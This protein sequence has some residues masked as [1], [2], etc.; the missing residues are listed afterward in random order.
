[1]RC[2]SLTKR[3]NGTIALRCYA[4]YLLLLGVVVRRV[5]HLKC[6]KTRVDSGSPLWDHIVCA[7]EQENC[8]RVFGESEMSY[9]ASKGFETILNSHLRIGTRNG[10]P[11]ID[12]TQQFD[13]ST[14]PLYQPASEV[15]GVL[16]HVDAIG[17]IQKE[18]RVRF[19]ESKFYCLIES[20]VGLLVEMRVCFLR[21]SL[22]KVA[23]TLTAA[24]GN[25]NTPP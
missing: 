17:D 18:S 12:D 23:V 13:M 20:H 22:H 25:T 6:D 7:P 5:I 16:V 1:M 4:S 8:F 21:G 19:V 9:R 15:E 10:S 14:V 3:Q 2:L 11:W 24:L